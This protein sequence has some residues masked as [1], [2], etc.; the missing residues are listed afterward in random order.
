MASESTFQCR[1]APPPDPSAAPPNLEYHKRL[2]ALARELHTPRGLTDGPDLEDWFR[3][4][5]L[6]EGGL[7]GPVCDSPRDA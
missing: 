7:L 3:A 2:A 1:E 5:R 6:L 4:R